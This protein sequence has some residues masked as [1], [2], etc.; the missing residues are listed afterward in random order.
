MTLTPTSRKQISDAPIVD[1]MQALLRDDLSAVEAILTERAA[2]P[3]KMTCWA[4]L[5]AFLTGT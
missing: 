3:V 2:S 4:T 5:G 1:R